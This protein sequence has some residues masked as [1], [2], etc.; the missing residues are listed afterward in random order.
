MYNYVLTLLQLGKI[1]QLNYITSRV[2]SSG[3]Q[4]VGEKL[5]PLSPSVS[6]PNSY[7]AIILK[8]KREVPIL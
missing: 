7:S 6:S 1:I 8:I 5:F 3:G 2:L 4:G